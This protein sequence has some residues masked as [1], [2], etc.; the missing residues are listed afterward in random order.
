MPKPPLSARLLPTGLAI[1]HLSA[2][3]EGLTLLAEPEASSARC[4][5][6]GASSRR[7][8]SR[9]TRKVS[10]LPWRG[11]AVRLEVRA[12]KFFCGARSCERAIF[13][14]RLPEIAARARKT[15]RLEEALLAIA[16]EL[17][18]EA[19]S[20][21]ARELGLLVSPDALLA[22]ARR[23]PQA[24]NERVRVLGV[25]DF[26]FRKGNA[27]GTILVDL[28]RRR[29]VDLLPECSQEGLASWLR[30]HPGVEV[31]TR[32]RSRIYKEGIAK[33]A[34]EAVQVADR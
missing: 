19:G 4:L 18:G 25:D 23:P 33:G 10:D 30:R 22:R 17:G 2:Q 15:A 26:A 21:L 9:Y 28:E 6:C 5:S 12:R 1:V 16:L 13:C 3:Q 27:Y 31:A 29:V 8:H 7:V 24:P 11:I 20:R 32:D 34:P 14:E